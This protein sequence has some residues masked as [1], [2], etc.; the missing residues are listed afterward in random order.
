[1]KKSLNVLTAKENHSL[2]GL[3]TILKIEA[4]SYNLYLERDYVEKR[5]DSLVDLFLNCGGL[6]LKIEKPTILIGDCADNKV[7]EYFNVKRSSK[8]Y[9][10]F[11]DIKITDNLFPGRLKET[12]STYLPGKIIRMPMANIGIINEKNADG[13]QYDVLAYFADTNTPAVIKKKNIVWCLFDICEVFYFLIT[14]SYISNDKFK[15]HDLLS[16]P[17]LHKLYYYAPNFLRKIIQGFLFNRLLAKVKAEHLD[18]FRTDFPIDCT[19]WLMIETVKA[20]ILHTGA[21]LITIK[22]FPSS[23]NSCILFT[24]DIEPTTYA[25]KKGIFKLLGEIKKYNL[26]SSI[27]L[28]AIWSRIYPG[29]IDDSIGNDN[30]EFHCQG[31]YHMG[32]TLGLTLEQL[33]HR[34]SLAKEILEK[35]LKHEIFGYRSPRL[36]RSPDLIKAI[37]HAGYKYSSISVDAD[38]ENTHFFGG[39]VSVN[40]PFRPPIM[41]GN[42]IRKASFLEFPVTA[43]D[44]ITPIFMGRTEQE[45]FDIYIKKITF[46]HDIG[47][48]FISLIHAGV[49]N[50][51][52]SQLRHRLLRFVIGAVENKKDIWKTGFRQAYEWWV[53]REGLN[54]SIAGDKIRIINN[55]DHVVSDIGIEVQTLSSKSNLNVTSLSANS[56]ADIDCPKGIICTI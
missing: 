14:E 54:I 34:V 50:E 9:K 18:N 29:F 12:L 25:Y 27:G 35:L 45:L 31:L 22:K 28:V 48:F 39:G 23:Y 1:M 10:R 21:P 53:T 43:P 11:I 13:K 40:F 19:G 16:F 4:I 37:E 41:D 26:K 36:N 44:C 55:N 46:V 47:G 8:A 6:N 56:Y 30:I 7:L 2:F 3:E 51:A 33:R 49:F 42:R 17:L 32:K 15:K 38:R 20:L 52:D 5:E 24:H